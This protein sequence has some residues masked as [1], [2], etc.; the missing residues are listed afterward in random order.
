MP[1]HNSDVRRIFGEVADLLDIQGANRFRVR[2]YRDAA[3]TVGSLSESVA[4]MV[5]NDEDLTELPGIGDDLADKIEE[6]VSTGELAMLQELYEDVPET[7]TDL[8]RVEGLGPKRV[9]KLYEEMEITTLDEL[10]RAAREGDVQRLEGFGDK[11]EQNILDHLE[12]ARAREERTLLRIAEE[13]AEPLV[14]YL[15]DFKPV[16]R[17]KVAG[18]YRRRRETVGDLDILVVADD[19]E[20]VA[21]HFVNYE[22][23]REV[24]S[25]GETRSSVVLRSNLQVD[26]RVIPEK[27]Y[28]AAMMYFTGSKAH[29]VALRNRAVE[30]DRKINEYGVFEQDDERVAGETEEGIY[31]L[32]DLPYIE[33]ELRED[34]GEIEAAAEDRLPDLVTLEDLRGDLQSHTSDSDGKDDLRAMVEAARDFGHDYFA[35]TDHSEHVGVTTGLDE[36]ALL[37]QMERID[38]L[39]GDCDD[40]RVLKSC[41][42]DILKDG[43]LALSE[44]VLGE[45]DLVLVA[46][47]TNFGL[48]EADQTERIVDA[49]ERDC[50][51]LLAHPTGRRLGDRPPYDVDLEAV[52]DAAVDFGCH[53]EI[54]AQPNRLDLDDVHARKARDRG[55]KLAIS[56]DAHAANHLDYLRFG[57]GQARRGWLEADDVLNA[58][59]WP[60]LRELLRGK[61]T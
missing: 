51:D 13:V 49:L 59:S 53:L 37:D 1:V 57:V 46:V 36:E 61:K 48:S 42:V 26:V 6:I 7:L 43:S 52:L 5:E 19:G 41:E 55:L 38:E 4:G 24:L 39:N 35:V 17:V 44:E 29:N 2:A 3:R 58:R 32:F 12:A 20:A 18:S 15:R 30:A 21:E 23:V 9:K 60:K 40:I 11:T 8:L 16:E 28:G 45:L 34:R 47:H 33:P 22:D 56:T 27:S 10:E 50:V 54:N 14:D 25:R 31:G